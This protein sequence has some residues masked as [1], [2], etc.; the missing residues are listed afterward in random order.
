MP[1]ALI[2]KPES[3]DSLGA[4]ET[5]VDSIQKS[6]PRRHGGALEFQR[7]FYKELFYD[8]IFRIKSTSQPDCNKRRK[9]KE[10]RERLRAPVVNSL[11]LRVQV[12]KHNNWFEH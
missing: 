7:R 12:R 3:V 11:S 9:D 8:L 6:S 5:L 4:P 1:A 2:F 10:H